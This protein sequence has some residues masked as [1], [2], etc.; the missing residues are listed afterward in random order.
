MILVQSFRAKQ[1]KSILDELNKESGRIYTLTMVSHWRTKRKKDLWLSEYDAMRMNDALSG[2]TI[3]HAHSRDAA[4]GGFYSACRT[5][6]ALKKAGFTEARYPYHP[7]TFRATTWKKSGVRIKEGKM[8]LARARWL[9]P[10]IVTLPENF[11]S[12]EILRSA[13]CF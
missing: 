2:S 6:K 13:S 1:P 11:E 8:I 3:L 5:T 12:C 4:Q 9:K 10:V 7:K